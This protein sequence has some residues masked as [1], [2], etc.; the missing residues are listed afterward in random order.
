MKVNLIKNNKN[1]NNNINYFKKYSFLKN[2]D[3]LIYLY[4]KSYL[5]SKRLGL[6][7]NKTR[8]EV[9][10]ST[11]KIIKQ[12]GTGSSR[13]G[14]IRNPLFRGGG[15][16]FG[17]IKRNYK[18]KINKKIYK[19]VKKILLSDKIINNKF[20]IIKKFYFLSHKTKYFINYFKYLNINIINKNKY[21]LIT[22][23]IYNKLLMS[24][25]N[26]NNIYINN[27]KQ[28][29]LYKVLYSDYIIF[30]G[31]NIDKYIINL[32]KKKK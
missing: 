11:R 16:I 15:K 26:I 18:I 5:A 4:V 19:L 3:H 24:S 9:K 10:G 1:I 20:F 2:K 22:D 14:N 7:K 29:N 17:P 12:K 32:I 31:E 30:I 28:I 27:F 21:L 6:S 23:K 8:G 25:N 13:K